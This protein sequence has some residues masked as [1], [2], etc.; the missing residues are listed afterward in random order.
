MFSIE[1]GPCRPA[2]LARSGGGGDATNIL[3]AFLNGEAFD[4]IG[5]SRMVYDMTEKAFPAKVGDGDFEHGHQGSN[6]ADILDFGL[7]GH[8]LNWQICTVK[9][10]IKAGTDGDAGSVEPGSR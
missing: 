7:W 4:Y 9:Q 1:L 5:S 8:F 10:F 3:F 6:P 2:D